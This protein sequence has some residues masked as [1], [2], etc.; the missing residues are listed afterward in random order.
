MQR[1]TFSIGSFIITP[2]NRLLLEA[3]IYSNIGTINS[4]SYNQDISIVTN[5]ELNNKKNLNCI[6][7]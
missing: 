1:H 3:E 4:I 6:I 2:E 5:T 7:L